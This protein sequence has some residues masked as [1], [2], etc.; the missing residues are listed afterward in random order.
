[1]LFQLGRDRQKMKMQDINL[2]IIG[3]TCCSTTKTYLEYL[4]SAGFRPRNLWLIDFVLPDDRTRKMQRLFGPDFGQFFHR[5]QDNRTGSSHWSK[6][7]QVTC[8]ALIEVAAPIKVNLF[9]EFQYENYA[10]NISRFCAEDYDDL[11]L[12]RQIQKTKGTAFL[13]TNGGIVPAT[14]LNNMNNRFLHMHPG[15]VPAVRGSD[16]FLWSCHAR[17]QPGVSCFYMSPEIDEGDIIQTLEFYMPDLSTLRDLLDEGNGDL[18][19]RALLF[20]LDPHLRGQILVKVLREN[21]RTDL[22]LLPAH[23]QPSVVRPAY[24]W[25]HPNIRDIVFKK[26]LERGPDLSSGKLLPVTTTER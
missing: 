16:C 10:E 13:Y 2:T 23:S 24:L 26:M 22:R 5:R 8:N 9:E 15:I 11:Y 19:Y 21:L 1:M 12:Q 25:M 4:K 20:A 18:A 7:F 6:E 3:D 17:K 14:I